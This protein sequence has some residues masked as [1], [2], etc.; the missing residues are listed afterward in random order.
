MPGS[1]RARRYAIYIYIPVNGAFARTMRICECVFFFFSMTF[2]Y[3]CRSR[4]ICKSAEWCT[5]SHFVCSKN[6]VPKE[7]QTH[8]YETL[9]VLMTHRGVY[10]ARG[11]GFDSLPDFDR[12]CVQ[13]YT[14]TYTLPPVTLTV[15]SRDAWFCCDFV[16]ISSN[17]TVS[18]VSQSCNIPCNT[19]SAGKF[20]CL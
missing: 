8:N 16:C 12:L 17:S 7:T 19:L 3:T 1:A 5:Q 18:V 4:H 6:V 20:P 10:M 11:S 14:Y 15:H 13:V 9:R 2:V